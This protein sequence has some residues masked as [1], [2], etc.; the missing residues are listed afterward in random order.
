MHDVGNTKLV[1]TPLQ[2]HALSGLER[3]ADHYGN[4]LKQ[5]CGLTARLWTM[6]LAT[7]ACSALNGCVVPVSSETDVAAGAGEGEGAA[8]GAVACTEGAAE[9]AG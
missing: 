6:F 7:A 5:G 4:W 2:L 9:G 1:A 3:D 8:A